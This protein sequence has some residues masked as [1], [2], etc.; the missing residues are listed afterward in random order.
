MDIGI[1]GTGNVGGTLGRRWAAG[2]HRIIF[3]ARDR[4][5]PR[6]EKALREIGSN[7]TV[8]PVQEVAAL[9]DLIVLAV[10]WGAAQEVI[11]AA[12]DLSRKVLVDATNPIAPGLELAVGHTMSA[13]ELIAGWAKGAHVVKAFNTLGAEHIANPRFGDEPLS[14]FI[15]GDHAEAKAV[16]AALAAELGFDVV[17]SGPLAAARLLEP[18]AMLW[19]RLALVE[20]A[21]REIAFKLLRRR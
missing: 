19:I 18:L 12:G 17:D 16:V 6:V 7:A 9:A 13:A 3:G 8:V 10:P 2:G 21:G 4:R 15:C 14:M 11:R 20:G 1:I 5:A